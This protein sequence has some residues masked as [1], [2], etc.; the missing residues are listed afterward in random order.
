MPWLPG[1][2]NIPQI[3]KEQLE[4]KRK[5][6]ENKWHTERQERERGGGGGYACR[7]STSKNSPSAASQ[8][9]LTICMRS[10]TVSVKLLRRSE[11]ETALMTLDSNLTG[12][13]KEWSSLQ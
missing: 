13:Q 6:V 1:R 11:I 8:Q 2:G 5:E 9:I 12:N 10:Y 4:K 3:L 7:V